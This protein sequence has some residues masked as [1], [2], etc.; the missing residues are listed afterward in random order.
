M[1]A[2]RRKFTQEFKDE[3]CREGVALLGS[4]GSGKSTLLGAIAG[5][6]P[7]E[8]GSVTVGGR[9]LND[10]TGDAASVVF[11]P[12]AVR[13]T[14]GLRA[15]ETVNHGEA[16]INTLEPA[17]GGIMIR[18]ALNPVVTVER[19]PLDVAEQGLESG[20]TVW[21]NLPREKVSI[22]PAR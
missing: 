18:T 4:H 19:S 11:H 12:S 17:S 5:I 15:D 22:Y 1:T 3:L 6:L 8:S 7:P 14:T 10:F 2:S 16:T 20:S 21:L 13:V 9:T